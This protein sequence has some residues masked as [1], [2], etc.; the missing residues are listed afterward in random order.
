MNSVGEIAGDSS[1]FLAKLTPAPIILALPR[2]RFRIPDLPLS[3]SY[4]AN[5]SKFPVRLST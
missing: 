2:I 1:N 4:F 5:A 3:R